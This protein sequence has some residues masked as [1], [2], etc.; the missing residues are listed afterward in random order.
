MHPNATRPVGVTIPTGQR[1]G[2]EIPDR[3]LPTLSIH[4]FE[5]LETCAGRYVDK[6]GK[7]VPGFFI[8]Y[9]GTWYLD[10]N[11]PNWFGTLKPLAAELEANVQRAYE[12]RT[13]A[14]D[15]PEIPTDD[16]V[17]VI[18]DE[19]GTAPLAPPADVDVVGAD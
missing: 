17:D 11:G 3:D 8:K 16:V 1:S 5:P 7:L 12:Q 6:S 9:A 19:E 15:V 14:R 10:P 18:A 4:N 2:E 13:K